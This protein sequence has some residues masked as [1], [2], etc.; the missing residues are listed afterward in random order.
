M[1]D[2]EYWWDKPIRDLWRE[3]SKTPPDTP[4]Y[5]RIVEIIR[6]RNSEAA[7]KLSESLV[8]ATRGLKVATWV[9]AVIAL[10]QALVLV[11]HR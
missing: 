6:I 11:W 7:N 2:D 5:Q 4:H 1:P 3:A 9:L 8:T 10:L